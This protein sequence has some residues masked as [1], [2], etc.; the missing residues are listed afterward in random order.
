GRRQARD[1]PGNCGSARILHPTRRPNTQSSQM[2]TTTAWSL[3]CSHCGQ[4]SDAS[5]LPTVCPKCGD[6]WL[7]KYRRLPGP[8]LKAGLRDAPWN[9][10]RYRGWT[11]VADGE[12]PVTLGE[13]MTP[14]LRWPALEQSLRLRT[15][16][17]KDE[18]QNPTGSFKARGLSAAVTGAVR[19]G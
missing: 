11:P 2:N 12:Q 16:W 6:P 18:S 8:A 10:W 4:T 14:L 3:E 13:G 5:G 7:V 15:V 1:S 19:G 17:I 9:M